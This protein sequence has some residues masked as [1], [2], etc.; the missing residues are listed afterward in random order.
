MIEYLFWLSAV[1][2]VIA[3]LLLGIIFLLLVLDMGTGIFRLLRTNSRLGKPHHTCERRFGI[4]HF[5]RT[6]GKGDK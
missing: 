6:Y 5:Y 1:C 4:N 2:F 3:T